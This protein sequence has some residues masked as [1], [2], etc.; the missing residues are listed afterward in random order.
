MIQISEWN[1]VQSTK[2]LYFK[3]S[4]PILSEIHK[5]NKKLKW[6]PLQERKQFTSFKKF[7]SMIAIVI[8]RH[9][10]IS[11]CATV[12]VAIIIIYLSVQMYLCKLQ[13]QDSIYHSNKELLAQLKCKATGFF[14]P[15]VSSFIYLFAYFSSFLSQTIKKQITEDFFF[16]FPFFFFLAVCVFNQCS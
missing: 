14:F 6:K 15:P 8:W 2:R 16:C 12:H 5:S 7:N 3:I 1:V 13:S 4:K 9:Q 11:V 10:Y